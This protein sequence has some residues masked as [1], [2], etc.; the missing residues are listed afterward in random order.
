M[1][2]HLAVQGP[3]GPV[4]VL[5]L[6]DEHVAA[7]MPVEEDGFVGTIVPLSKIGGSFA[8]VGEYA[9]D[10]DAIKDQVADAV[11]WRL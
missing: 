7:A 10:I 9:G 6:P 5:L 2:A 11:R 3:Q 1:V 8:V 4:T